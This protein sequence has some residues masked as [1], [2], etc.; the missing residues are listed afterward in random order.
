MKRS[1]FT[2]CSIYAAL[3]KL[4]SAGFIVIRGIKRMIFMLSAYFYLHNYALYAVV[5]LIMIKS[6][7]LL[8]LLLV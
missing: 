6:L 2:A 5:I 3:H 4:F 1:F 7:T 8:Q